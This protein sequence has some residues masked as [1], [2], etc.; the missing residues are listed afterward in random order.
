[1]NDGYARYCDPQMRIVPIFYIL[2]MHA[3]LFM[4]V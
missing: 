1:M 2:T 4:P 3:F